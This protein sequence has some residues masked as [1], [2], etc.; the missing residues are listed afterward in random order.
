MGGK[1]RRLVELLTGLQEYP[2][3]KVGLTLFARPED[4]PEI[5]KAFPQVFDMDVDLFFLKRK[6]KKDLSLFK[7]RFRFY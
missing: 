4:Y 7:G 6:T 1:E 2:D 5:K 3:V